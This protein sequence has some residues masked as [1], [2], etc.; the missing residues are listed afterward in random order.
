MA[1]ISLPTVQRMESSNGQVRGVVDTL[2]KVITALEHAGIELLVENMPGA[3]VGRGVR[4]RID[5]PNREARKR[6]GLHFKNAVRF[7]GSNDVA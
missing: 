5:T 7:V 4:M 2:V 1:G 3:G 6:L